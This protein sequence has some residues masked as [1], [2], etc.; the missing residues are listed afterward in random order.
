[1][2]GILDELAQRFHGEIADLERM[3][4]RISLTWQGFE[5]PRTTGSSFSTRSP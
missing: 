4:Q 5:R 2:N 3:A 1:M